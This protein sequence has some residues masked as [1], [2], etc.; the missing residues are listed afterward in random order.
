VTTRD[1]LAGSP[2]PSELAAIEAAHSFELPAEFVALHVDG[3]LDQASPRYLW[4]FEAEWIPVREIAG[5]AVNLRARLVPFAFTGAGDLWCW[6][7]DR[8]GT[9]GPAVVECPRDEELGSL[10]APSFRG[11]LL[12]R[13]LDY[14]G[15][16]YD[17]V[18]VAREQLR[19]WVKDF[20]P[21][22]PAAWTTFVRQVA[23]G[24]EALQRLERATY[25]CLL[26]N[27]GA[28][29]FLRAEWA[30]CDLDTPLAWRADAPPPS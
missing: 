25:P 21:L 30:G 2:R 15:G 18:A 7:L 20:A 14:A 28:L 8:T 19:A 24:P 13:T 26:P 12:R 29:A 27:E 16:G 9:H 22:F 6:D 17:D 10:Y 1:R 4:L 5:P 11:F 3:S 23:D